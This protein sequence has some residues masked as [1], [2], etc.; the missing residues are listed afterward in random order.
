MEAVI[1]KWG[2]SAAVR[3]PAT[4]L[5]EVNLAPGERVEIKSEDGRIVITP[6][7]TRYRLADLL[8]G[9]TAEN[10]H[11]EVDAGAALGREAL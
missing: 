1:Q 11:A 2:N 4:M 10:L 9:V 5:K 8:A 7:K 3:L 6:L